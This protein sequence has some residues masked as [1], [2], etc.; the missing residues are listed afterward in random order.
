M[1]DK[2]S[3]VRVVITY[4]ESILEALAEALKRTTLINHGTAVLTIE[5][6]D[7]T[8][9]NYTLFPG[10]SDLEQTTHAKLNHYHCQRTLH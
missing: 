8:V 1:S 2:Q 10:L 7:G 4:P 9:E 6:A 3:A 5:R